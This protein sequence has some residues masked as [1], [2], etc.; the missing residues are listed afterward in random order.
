[1]ADNNYPKYGDPNFSF[2]DDMKRRLGN[3]KDVMLEPPEQLPED[4]SSMLPNQ[5][6]AGQGLGKM[7]RAYQALLP[8]PVRITPTQD[9]ISKLNPEMQNLYKDRPP[10]YMD[11]LAMIG[12]VKFPK[13]GKAI[14]SAQKEVTPMIKKYGNAVG[15][16][17]PADMSMMDR[18]KL[19]KERSGPIRQMETFEQAANSKELERLRNLPKDYF[20]KAR[21]KASNNYFNELLEKYK[22]DPERL[23]ELKKLLNKEE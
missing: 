5:Y 18:I 15:N 13:V 10:M 16:E 12:S 20:D 2:I 11:P 23:E 6:L 22:N 14:G 8:D 17:L 7:Y 19:A 1:M 9:Q 3:A 4:D 21:E